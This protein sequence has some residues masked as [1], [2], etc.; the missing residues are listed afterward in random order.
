MTGQKHGHQHVVLDIYGMEVLQYAT[1][2]HA[3]LNCITA[4]TRVQLIAVIAVQMA[5]NAILE[6]QKT[7]TA[8][9]V[10]RLYM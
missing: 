3:L 7:A 4:R 10:Q 6:I 9:V 2:Y 5:M 1:A 8:L